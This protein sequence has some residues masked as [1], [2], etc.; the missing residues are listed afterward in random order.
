MI[1]QSVTKLE[2]RLLCKAIQFVLY[3]STCDYLAK[4]RGWT[5]PRGFPERSA[6]N[7][8]VQLEIF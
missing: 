6:H 7:M 4:L 8:V 3:F 1:N 2:N 5:A